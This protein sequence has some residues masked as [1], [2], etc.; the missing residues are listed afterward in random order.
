MALLA[1]GLLAAGC[2]QAPSGS[3]GAP[4]TDVEGALRVSLNDGGNSLYAPD[5]KRAWWGTFGSLDMCTE[6]GEPLVIEDVTYVFR[7]EPLQVR[8][9]VRRVNAATFDERSGAELPIAALRGSLESLFRERYEASTLTDP[10]G[11]IVDQRCTDDLLTVQDEL[12]TSMRVDRSGGW[13]SEI[14]IAFR[15]GDSESTKVVDWN[16]V[17]CGRDMTEESACL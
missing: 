17:M 9:V 13:I 3:R 14:Q 8:S 7:Y 16:Y 15:S 2:E 1:T 11:H 6:T 5:G 10:A 4:S 12:L